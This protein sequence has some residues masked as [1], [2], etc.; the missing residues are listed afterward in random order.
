ME[1]G[2]VVSSIRADLPGLAPF[3]WRHWE[4][5]KG[6]MGAVDCGWFAD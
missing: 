5:E 3:L 6:C 4:V 1:L 2:G